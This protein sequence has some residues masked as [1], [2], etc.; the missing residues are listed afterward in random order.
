MLSECRFAEGASAEAHAME[1]R[2]TE[3][4]KRGRLENGTRYT[5]HIG[6]LGFRLGLVRHGYWATAN[7]GAHEGRAWRGFSCTHY[8]LAW[9]RRLIKGYLLVPFLRAQWRGKGVG[10]TSYPLIALAVTHCLD[11][12]RSATFIMLCQACQACCSC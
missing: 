2:Q 5:S 4:A 1:T 9:T 10:W 3:T 12:G 8:L 7:W 6:P 11:L